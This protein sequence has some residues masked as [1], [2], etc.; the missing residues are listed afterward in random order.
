[1]TTIKIVG[2]IEEIGSI[3]FIVYQEDS[4]LPGETRL[5][6]R[7]YDL[8]KTPAQVINGPSHPI[9]E[10]WLGDYNNTRYCSAGVGRV[11]GCQPEEYWEDGYPV[12]DGEK[13]TRY[14]TTLK[15]LDGQELAEFLD[16]N[17]IN[18]SENSKRYVYK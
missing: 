1:M 2:S 14:H 13:R 4:Y 18:W 15:L 7:Y 12:F 5:H 17:G 9:I 11:I 3:R 6:T 10:G 16:A 8:R